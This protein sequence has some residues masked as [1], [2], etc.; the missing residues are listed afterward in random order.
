VVLIGFQAV[1]SAGI[2]S[3]LS[4]EADSVRQTPDGG[5]IVAGREAFQPGP[6]GFAPVPE[7]PG[8][9]ASGSSVACCPTWT[10]F[11]LPRCG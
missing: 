6:A 10:S 1:F 11:V 3:D 2:T 4:S 8:S 5:Y 9:A 7:T